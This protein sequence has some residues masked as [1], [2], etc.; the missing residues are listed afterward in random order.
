[1]ASTHFPG[2]WQT[3]RASNAVEVRSGILRKN[4]GLNLETMDAPLPSDSRHP[5]RPKCRRAWPENR[6][7]SIEAS[8]TQAFDVAGRYG[9]QWKVPPAPIPADATSGF[10][11]IDAVQPNIQEND[12]EGTIRLK[13]S[14]GAKA[15]FHSRDIS[16]GH[17]DDA[18]T[19]RLNRSSS[20]SRTRLPLQELTLSSLTVVPGKALP[21]HDSRRSGTYA[22]PVNLVMGKHTYSALY[23]GR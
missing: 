14:Q 23:V 6:S 16:A 15:A 18:F 21:G 19:S 20:T 13:K 1:V 5:T 4:E 2:K 22:G 17:G 12:I 10:A 3:G 8:L 9:H 7:S 11:T